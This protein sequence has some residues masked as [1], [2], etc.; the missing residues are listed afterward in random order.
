MFAFFYKKKKKRFWFKTLGF[1]F[2]SF[3][4]G[5]PGHYL[6]SVCTLCL[7]ASKYICPEVM[8]VFFIFKGSRDTRSWWGRGRE[9]MMINWFVE[10]RDKISDWE[11]RKVWFR[12]AAS[13]RTDTGRD[14]RLWRVGAESFICSGV[15]VCHNGN[16]PSQIFQRFRRRDSHKQNTVYSPSWCDPLF[17]HLYCFQG[18]KAVLF[19]NVKK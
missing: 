2:R 5:R 14:A 3:I 8:C 16:I 6:A 19:L 18:K 4:L 11:G 7:H 15:A 10:K 17:L 13:H 9:K 1:A 12:G